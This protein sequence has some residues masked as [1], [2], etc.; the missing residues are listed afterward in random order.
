MNIVEG[1]RYLVKV[2]KLETFGAIVELSDKTTKLIHISNISDEYIADVGD[3]LSV[4]TT[5]SAECISDA[6]FGLQ[7]SLKHLKLKSSK[8][9]NARNRNLDNMIDKSYSDFE[10]KQPRRKYNHRRGRL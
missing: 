4:D 2:I 7:L 9:I 8:R 1:E 3:Y 10:E 6:K 5:Y